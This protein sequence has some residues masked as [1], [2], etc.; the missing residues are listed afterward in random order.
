MSELHP[1][2]N[3]S[4]CA[5][6]QY[7]VSQPVNQLITHAKDVTC[8][9]SVCS[10]SA[11]NIYQR[12]V[13]TT[14]KNVLRV[15]VSQLSCKLFVAR[16]S[17]VCESNFDLAVYVSVYDNSHN[18]SHHERCRPLPPVTAGCT[19]LLL[20]DAVDCLCFTVVSAVL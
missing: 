20:R 8:P 1:Q 18:I 16:I 2:H 7:I 6:Q 4:I 13:E 19:K 12:G 15:R 10:R 17:G 11:G 5:V 14:R 9:L 3:N